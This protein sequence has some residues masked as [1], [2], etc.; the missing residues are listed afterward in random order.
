MAWVNIDVDPE[1]ADALERAE[2]SVAVWLPHET[3]GEPNMQFEKVHAVIR[4]YYEPAAQF[5]KIEVWTRKADGRVRTS[6]SEAVTPGVKA[7]D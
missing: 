6:R 2:D 4:K 5:G 3:S 7:M 1:F